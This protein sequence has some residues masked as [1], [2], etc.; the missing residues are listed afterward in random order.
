MKEAVD[1]Y[2]KIVIAMF[3]FIGPFFTLLIA[4]FVPAIERSKI[5]HRARLATLQEIIAKNIIDGKGFELYVSE[6]KRE[7]D[8]LQSA[9]KR[10]ITLLNPKLQ[11]GRLALGLFF[12][13][14]GIALYYFEHSQF[15]QSED[16]LWKVIALLASGIGF[17]Y[18]VVVLWQLFCTIIRLKTED[19]IAKQEGSKPQL[20]PSQN[21]QK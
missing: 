18:C 16:P 10:E 21:V 15:W 13:I 3:G 19:E 1:L 11:V 7:L 5:R 4:L 2:A 20:M 8:R 12:S 17:V 6:G 14:A 9:N